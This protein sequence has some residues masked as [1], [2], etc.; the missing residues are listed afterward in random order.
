[1]ANKKI[2]VDPTA[3]ETVHLIFTRY[4]E[5]GSVKA[6]ARDLERRGIRTKERKLATGRG[7]GGA[8]FG[9]GALAYLLRNRFYIG[10]VVYRGQAF[11]WRS[12]T[13]PRSRSVRGR[14]SQAVGAGGR[15]RRRCLPGA[16]CPPPPSRGR[17]H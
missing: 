12:R 7:I 13:D 4:L 17:R 3:A 10:E 9:V 1:V 2:V 14:T 11:R 16:C 5:L 6:L 8:A 15:T